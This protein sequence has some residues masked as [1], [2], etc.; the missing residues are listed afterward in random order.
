MDSE[1]FSLWV[2]DKFL[3]LLLKFYWLLFTPRKI[4]NGKRF[5]F[6]QEEGDGYS[7]L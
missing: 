1:E 4:L 3:R 2:F 6:E 7:V 5:A